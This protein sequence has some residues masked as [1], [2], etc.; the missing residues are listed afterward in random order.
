MFVVGPDDIE[1]LVIMAIDLQRSDVQ[2]HIAW[3]HCPGA[4]V[5]TAAL[6]TETTGPQ[7]DVV[8]IPTRAIRPSYGQA[9]VLSV[10]R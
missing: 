7:P 3:L 10:S 9:I 5:S 6:R 1:M 2:W 8:E 4:R